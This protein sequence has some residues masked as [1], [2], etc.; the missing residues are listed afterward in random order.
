[1]K[2]LD[3][4]LSKGKFWKAA[5]IDRHTCGLIPPDQMP[6]L[7]AGISVPRT[8]YW[9]FGC[10]APLAGMNPQGVP[11]ADLYE[12]GVRY[13]VCL[14]DDR[15]DYHPEPPKVLHAVELKGL[16]RGGEPKNP[17]KERERIRSA[18]DAIVPALQA[19]EGVVVHCA[20]GRGRTGTVIG[21][22]LRRLGFATNQ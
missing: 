1:M 21:C 15:P 19:G 4:G 20:G 8:L 14:T 2:E 9:L 17:S 10:P 16:V 5:G 11:W 6:E 3:C 12:L 7:P 22:T 18:V 13:V